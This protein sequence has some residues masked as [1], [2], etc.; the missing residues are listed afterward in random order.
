VLITLLGWAGTAIVLGAYVLV[1]TRRIPPGSPAYGVANVVGSAGLGVNAYANEAWPLVALNVV[2]A[3]VGA[4]TLV[5]F[6]RRSA[7]STVSAST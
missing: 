6:R 5:T 1:S 2:W 4:Y 7:R 3:L